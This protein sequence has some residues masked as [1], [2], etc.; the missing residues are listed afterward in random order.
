MQ[1]GRWCDRVGQRRVA[2]KPQ[3]QPK[4]TKAGL[5]FS[6][7]SVL[8]PTIAQRLDSCNCDSQHQHATKQDK[9]VRFWCD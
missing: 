9:R 5:S 2:G 1:V 4:Q 6:T 7:F 3:I 8:P